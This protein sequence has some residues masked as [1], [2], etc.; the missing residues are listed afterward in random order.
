MHERWVRES[1]QGEQ[2]NDCLSLTA[3]GALDTPGR[4]QWGTQV[5]VVES[6]GRGIDTK[7]RL[8]EPQQQQQHEE[9]TVL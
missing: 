8:C 9:A 1:E 6:W 5:G 7:G 2:R 3:T 4:S